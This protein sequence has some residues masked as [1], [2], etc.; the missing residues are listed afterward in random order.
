MTFSELP[1]MGLCQYYTKMC[2]SNGN[3]IRNGHERYLS[4][5]LV[6]YR[7]YFMDEITTY[8]HVDRFFYNPFQKGFTV[9]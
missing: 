5:T 6:H 4:F 3:I 7:S 8:M 1:P 2:C 9:A